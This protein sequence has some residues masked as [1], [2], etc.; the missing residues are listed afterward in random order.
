VVSNS[1]PHDVGLDLERRNRYANTSSSSTLE[2]VSSSSYWTH[3][4]NLCPTIC[5][6]CGMNHMTNTRRSHGEGR[7]WRSG[8]DQS[9]A[10][11]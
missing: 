8:R 3:H 10:C 11:I 6:T 7:T 1:F 2:K 4:R 5:R 9:S